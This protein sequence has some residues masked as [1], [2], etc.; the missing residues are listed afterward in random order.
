MIFLMILLQIF[1]YN[2]IQFYA[3]KNNVFFISDLSS[4]LQK[5]LIA[6]ILP[7]AIWANI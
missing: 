1:L 2:Y 7:Q 4:A 3:E 6:C 5:V